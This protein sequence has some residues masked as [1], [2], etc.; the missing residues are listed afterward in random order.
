MPILT[1]TPRERGRLEHLAPAPPRDADQLRRVDALLAR[2]WPG[3][4]DGRP[5]PSGSAAP[6][7]TSGSTRFQEHRKGDLQAATIDPHGPRP[8]P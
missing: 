1:L 3:G 7:S 4:L 8:L 6:H 2:R 5:M